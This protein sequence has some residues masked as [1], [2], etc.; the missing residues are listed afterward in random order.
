MTAA[1]GPA[2][3][4][5][6]TGAR[7]WRQLLIN[8]TQRELRSQ[9]KNSIL[10]W[11][12]SF[13]NPTIV[14]AVYALVFT[15][16]FRSVPVVGDPS[17]IASF[18]LFLATGIIPWQFH[19]TG[20]NQATGSVWS[21]RALVGKIHFPRTVLPT[22]SI[23]ARLATY[24]IEMLVVLVALWLLGG[25]SAFHH[26]PVLAV[27]MAFHAIFVLGIAMATSALNVYFRDISYL[28]GVLLQPWFWLTPIIYPSTRVPADRELL[29]VPLTTLYRANPMLHFIEAYRDLLYH[30]RLPGWNTMLAIGAFTAVSILAGTLIFLRLE[31]RFVEEF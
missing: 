13:I 2:T 4:A 21:N 9:F 31:D 20:L 27:L 24:A 12:W 5:H 17:G 28:V 14:L 6:A 29:G 16:I 23:L 30:V 7:L 3:S 18:P 1:V 10:G 19:A 11:G 22:A 26:V 8:L 15:M 25:V